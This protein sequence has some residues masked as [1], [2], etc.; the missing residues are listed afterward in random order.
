MCKCRECELPGWPASEGFENVNPGSIVIFAATVSFAI[1]EVDRK[2]PSERFCESL[3]RSSC[4]SV[5][6]KLDVL[7]GLIKSRRASRITLQIL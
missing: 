5:L 1:G 2:E 7:L 4:S 3:A 6:L